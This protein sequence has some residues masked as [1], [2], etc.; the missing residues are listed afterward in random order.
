MCLSRRTHA[1]CYRNRLPRYDNVETRT[2]KCPFE[3]PVCYWILSSNLEK[4]CVRYYPGFLWHQYFFL[5]QISVS[6]LV[7]TTSTRTR[8]NVPTRP[9]VLTWGRRI[10]AAMLGS[11]GAILAKDARSK[12][13][14]LST[15]SARMEEENYLEVEV[16]IFITTIALCLMWG[17]MQWVTL[18]PQLGI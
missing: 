6:E 11:D 14:L 17:W 12:V 3:D 10:V 7:F 4:Y 5:S 1:W 9:P 8:R 16:R 15:N 18:L 13:P 2:R